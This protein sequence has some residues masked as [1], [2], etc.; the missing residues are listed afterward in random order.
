VPSSVEARPEILPQ[1]HA[2]GKFNRAAKS[3]VRPG[4]IR[5][6]RLPIKPRS[7]K[8]R[9]SNRRALIRRGGMETARRKLLDEGFSM[10]RSG[11]HALIAGRFTSTA[12]IARHERC[13]ERAVRITLSLAFLAPAIVRAGVEGRLP[14]GLNTSRLLRAAH[15]VGGTAADRKLML[16]ARSVRSEGLAVRFRL[17][18]PRI[19][20]KPC[21]SA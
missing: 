18:P 11:K 13:S 6:L 10:A 16:F 4:R 19:P 2:G 3:R 12:E 20:R 15:P 8:D 9:S 1:T 7:L 14:Y 17:G 5:V 21:A